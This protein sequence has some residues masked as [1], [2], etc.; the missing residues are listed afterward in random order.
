[1]RPSPTCWC[2][3]CAS[4]TNC[5]MQS[6][7][8]NHHPSGGLGLRC[9][10]GLRRRCLAM[11]CRH[12]LGAMPRLLRCWGGA[13]GPAL[14]VRDI[15]TS[16]WDRKV[17]RGCRCRLRRCCALR[18]RRCWDLRDAHWLCVVWNSPKSR[19]DSELQCLRDLQGRRNC[20][21]LRLRCLCHLLQ[22]LDGFGNCCVCCAKSL[23]Q[24]WMVA[25]Q[26]LQLLVAA[27]L[28]DSTRSVRGEGHGKC[29]AEKGGV[30]C[31]LGLRGLS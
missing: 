26:L 7:A 5:A 10:P 13:F 18:C 29:S 20:H 31:E 17:C 6:C 25:E 28:Q 12:G 14:S 16:H 9:D 15:S 21:P 2:C 23:C 27:V 11:S 4:P 3:R 30:I 8:T 1:M 19:E 24:L 22:H